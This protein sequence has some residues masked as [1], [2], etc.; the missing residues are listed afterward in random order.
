MKGA[1]PRIMI[2]W[3]AAGRQDQR[4]TATMMQNQS[5]WCWQWRQQQPDEGRGMDQWQQGQQ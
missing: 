3:P 2:V 4:S 5:C 1:H